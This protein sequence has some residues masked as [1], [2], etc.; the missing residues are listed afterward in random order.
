MFWIR[1]IAAR[2]KWL[3]ASLC[4]IYVFNSWKKPQQSYLFFFYFP[5]F[6]SR[7]KLVKIS[8]PTLMHFLSTS[9]EV[10]SSKVSVSLSSLCLFDL[11]LLAEVWTLKDNF[12]ET[13]ETFVSQSYRCLQNYNLKI[14]YWFMEINIHWNISKP[15]YMLKHSLQF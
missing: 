13:A 14:K 15:Q 12:W 1:N 9:S 5:V 8:K 7:K 6:R 4:P 10:C 3:V 2:K 11:L